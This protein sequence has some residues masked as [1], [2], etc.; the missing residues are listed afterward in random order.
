MQNPSTL[1]TRTTH[2][3]RFETSKPV[4]LGSQVFAL[5]YFLKMQGLVQPNETPSSVTS[6][7]RRQYDS[8]NSFSQPSTCIPHLTSGSIHLQTFQPSNK[9]LCK[10]QDR[11]SD[12]RAS[13]WRGPWLHA[14][15]S[16][17]LW[18]AP[19][20]ADGACRA[21]GVGM[22]AEYENR[23]ASAI[24]HGSSLLQCYDGIQKALSA[25]LFSGL[26]SC[27]SPGISSSLR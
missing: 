17:R 9:L 24:H 23:K 21:T 20:V 15:I 16:S 5:T 26:S 8:P 6:G 13:Y 14:A 18:G 11:D 2:M 25:A 10:C 19:A 1:N 27:N 3:S 22:E 7:S 4:R 12:L